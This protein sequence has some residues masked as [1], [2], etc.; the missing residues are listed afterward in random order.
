MTFV[1]RAH[2]R[3]HTHIHATGTRRAIVLTQ[4]VIGAP[5]VAAVVKNVLDAGLLPKLQAQLRST[6]RDVALAAATC[7]GCMASLADFRWVVDAAENESR[8]PR[9]V[10]AAMMSRCVCVCLCAR[11]CG[12]W[13]VCCVCVGWVGVASGVAAVSDLWLALTHCVCNIDRQH[14]LPCLLSLSLLGG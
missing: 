13:C 7:L 5:P 1:A 3:T 4:S 12:V 11:V 9:A 6:N 8:L 10:K 2:G 14:W